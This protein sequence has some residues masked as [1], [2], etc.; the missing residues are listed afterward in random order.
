MADKRFRWN[1]NA[2]IPVDGAP[3]IPLYVADSWLLTEGNVV[4]L[5]RH[6]ERFASSAAAQ[7]LVRSVAPFTAAVRAALPHTGS[8]FP[9]IDLTERGELELWLRPAPPRSDTIVLATAATD[10]RSEPTI[11]GPD[12]PALEGLRQSAKGLGADDAVILDP[13]GR[14]IDGATTCLL[15]WRNGDIFLPPA[16]AV[17]VD[18]IT[19]KVVQELAV[20]RGVAVTEEWASPADLLGTTVWAVNSLHGIRDVSRWV[21]HEGLL[22]NPPLLAQWRAAY[23]ARA[24]EI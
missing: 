23:D 24:T 12:I 5:D 7:G 14:I 1:G 15:W 2:L 16:S 20:A 9:R 4:A 19:V 10:V 3:I 8:H 11:K 21:G 17:R 22:S 6:F 18:S 13:S